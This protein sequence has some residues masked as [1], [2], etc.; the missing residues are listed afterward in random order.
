VN[1]F[2]AGCLLLGGAASCGYRA[3]YPQGDAARLHVRLL[4]TLVADAVVGDEV[5]AG[6]REE[7]AIAGAF[8]DGQGFP[9]M[10]IEV[11]REDESA[12]GIT[13]ANGRPVARASGL[14]V[15]ARAWI[16][17]G[18]DAPPVGE[19]GDLSAEDVVGVSRNETLDGRLDPAPVAFADADASRAAARRLGHT[20]AL[21][22]LS[23]QSAAVLCPAQSP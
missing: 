9:S 20:L 14:G 10:T 11:L 15:R 21:K 5:L 13:A 6:A 1:R 3:V 12:L 2:V 16:A 17:C 19:T 8:A 23:D 7:L 18:A 22:L 4:R